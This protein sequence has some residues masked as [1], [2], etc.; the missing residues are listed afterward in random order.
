MD[1]ERAKLAT[2]Y[3]GFMPNKASRADLHLY[4]QCGWL[5]LVKELLSEPLRDIPQN[6]RRFLRRRE[7]QF[8][9]PMG[10]FPFGGLLPRPGPDGLGVLLGAFGGDL[11][12]EY[13]AYLLI[14]WATKLLLNWQYL[15]LT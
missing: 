2:V 12:A 8:S 10:Y 4:C 6:R 7:M 11:L 1:L 15:V 3:V 14:T 9:T 13:M 5:Q